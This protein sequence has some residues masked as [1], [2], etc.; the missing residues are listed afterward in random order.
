[1]AKPRHFDSLEQEVFLNLWRTYDRLRALEE[2]LFRKHD[3]TPQQYN[4]L[5]LLRGEHPKTLPTLTL[6]A[7]LVSRAPDI[8]RMLDKL[9]Q[10]KLVYRERPADNRRVVQIGITEEGRALLRRLD[11]PVR[12]CHGQQLGHLAPAQL[13]ELAELLRAARL[14]HEDN[15]NPWS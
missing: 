13:R 12:E 10:Q 4:A 14:P 6:A 15:T 7:R 1:M 5:R 8:T 2:E 3:L 9:E 11:A